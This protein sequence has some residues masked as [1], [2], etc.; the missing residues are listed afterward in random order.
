MS[1]LLEIRHLSVAL[2]AG[3]EREFA[4]QDVSID[5][6]HGQTVCVV[7]ESG[8]GKSVMANAVMRLLP[9]N[10]LHVAQGEIVF[11]GRDVLGLDAATMRTLR[12]SRDE[13]AEPG[14]D[15]R[16]ADR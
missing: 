15:R 11:E 8:S 10:V 3:S 2:P 4:V 6:P 1:M 12:G 14:H 13:L 7:G 16:R 9:K 5:V